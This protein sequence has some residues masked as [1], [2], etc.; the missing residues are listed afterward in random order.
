MRPNTSGEC[1]I[2]ISWMENRLYA[3]IFLIGVSLILF[4]L[5]NQ[6]TSFTIAVFLAFWGV[7][8]LVTSW[9]QTVRLRERRFVSDSSSQ[10]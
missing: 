9:I 3:S 4:L 1:Q 7:G 8:G 6:I 2:L 10:R 5:P